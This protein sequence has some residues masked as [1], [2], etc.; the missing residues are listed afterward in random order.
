M[1]G[2]SGNA[3]HIVADGYDRIALRYRD[4]S[5]G[6]PIRLR[7]LDLLLSLLPAGSDVLD[8]GCGAGEPVTRRLAEQ[9]RVVGVD[10]S[11]RQLELAS[12]AAPSA[13]FLLG[14]L[15]EIAFPNRSF[16]AVVAFY[17]LT[18][19]PR[20]RHADVL[21]RI[22][23]WLRPGGLVLISMGT[24]DD[25]GAIQADWLGASMYFSSFDAATNRALVRR[26]GIRIVSDEIVDEDER[27]PGA[28]FLWVVGRID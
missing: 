7:Y 21:G 22:V 24:R 17:A 1:R 8:L 14:D 2:L 18:H 15:S 5:S 11:R 10:V 19:V 4:W 20:M 9:H 6:A 12:E 23:Q 26:A 27:D 13:V 3:V 25:P 28:R 16:D